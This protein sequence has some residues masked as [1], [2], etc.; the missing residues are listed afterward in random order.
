MI[1]PPFA[2]AVIPVVPEVSL[3]AFARAPRSVVVTA[4]EIVE[5]SPPLPRVNETVPSADR[6]ARVAVVDA[7]AV[8]P[9]VPVSA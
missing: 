6:P 7:V 2:S 3:I 8:T 4:A 5:V 1:S 9:V